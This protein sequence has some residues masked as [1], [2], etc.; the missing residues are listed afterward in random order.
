M[1]TG[2][3]DAE[4]E[5]QTLGL[6]DAKSKLIGKK[7]LILGRIEGRRRSGQQRIRWLNGVTE[8]SGHEFEQTLG[9][10]ERQASLACCS[11]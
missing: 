6:P 5:A 8:L 2:R 7:P 9:D 1:F 10:S 3:T 4:G 11:P